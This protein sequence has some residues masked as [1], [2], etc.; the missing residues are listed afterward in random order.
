MDASTTH[1]AP[2]NHTGTSLENVERESLQLIDAASS[3][4][5]AL[6]VPA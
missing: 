5:Q 2:Y 1:A 6:S 3:D 4:A